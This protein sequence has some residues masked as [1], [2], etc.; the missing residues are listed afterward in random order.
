MP[1]QKAID[2]G[3]LIANVPDGF[4]CTDERG[5]VFIANRAAERMLGRAPGELL[6]KPLADLIDVRHL[7]KTMSAIGQAAPTRTN[8]RRK[9]GS[10]VALEVSLA[11]HDMPWGRV[12]S[13]VLRELS[14]CDRTNSTGRDIGRETFLATAAH[15]MRGPI[16][17]ILTSLRTVE[18]A[19]ASGNPP[20]PD[21]IPRAIRQAV[22]LGRLVDAIL[23]DAAAMERGDLKVQVAEFDIAAL[24]VDIVEDFRM[25]SPEHRIDYHGPASGV[26]IVS[27]SGRVHQILNNLIEN[28]MK[29]SARQ[30]PVNV[31]LNSLDG[32]VVLR[33]IDA[34]IGIP[35]A[36]QGGVFGKYT[37]G[38]NVPVAS[39]G[40]GVGLYMARGLAERL[41]GSLT[42]ESEV[43]RGSAFSLVLPKEWPE[44][45]N[46]HQASVHQ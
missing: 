20:P 46:G 38:S 11:D 26:L 1:Q 40:L 17:P 19:L 15:Q 28:A 13:A 27:D 7:R 10:L 12:T 2:W 23:N 34:G 25:A 3:R 4:V 30:N 6:S 37:R 5:R 29:Y 35:L 24:A 41:H 16:Q 18:L 31:V 44:T 22:R 8:G 45:I 39:S 43:G 36:E 21:T 32:K 42:L 14:R 9:D 33:V